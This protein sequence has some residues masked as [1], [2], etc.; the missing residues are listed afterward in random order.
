LLVIP[1][2]LHDIARASN[3]EKSCQLVQDDNGSFHASCGF[4]NF[5]NNSQDPTSRQLGAWVGARHWIS[6]NRSDVVESNV[7]DDLACTAKSINVLHVKF[8]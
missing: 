2:G 3:W 6:Q 1:Q 8:R 7:V 5:V 4:P